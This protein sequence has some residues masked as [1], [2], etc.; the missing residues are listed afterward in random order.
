MNPREESWREVE[1]VAMNIV[2]QIGDALYEALPPDIAHKYFVDARQKTNDIAID[3]AEK[4]IAQALTHRERELRKEI[5]KDL[6]IVAA[7]PG[8]HVALHDFI[9]HSLT[10]PSTEDKKQ[11]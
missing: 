7:M 11:V 2:Y 1:A 3:F 9:Y 6:E 4:L 5:R 10:T 8:V